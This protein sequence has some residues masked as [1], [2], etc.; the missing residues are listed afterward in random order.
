MIIRSRLGAKSY[1]AEKAP[2]KQW[3]TEHQ[4]VNQST[5]LLERKTS[6]ILIA[7]FLV[8]INHRYSFIISLQFDH[9]DQRQLQK[10]CEFA[11]KI[12]NTSR[13]QTS[14]TLSTDV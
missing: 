9:Y 12:Q 4:L 2:Q 5:K 8:S 14:P 13:T 10:P 3:P 1:S 7:T 6:I 11:D